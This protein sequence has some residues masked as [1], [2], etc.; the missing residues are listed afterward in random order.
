MSV[1]VLKVFLIEN[2]LKHTLTVLGIT[3][4]SLHNVIIYVTRYRYIAHLY[5]FAVHA[6]FYSDVVQCR[7]STPADQVCS[8]K[9]VIGL[10]CRTCFSMGNL[11]VQVSI[12][13]SVH[14][15]VPLSVNIY[16]WC[17][18]SATPL[19]VLCQS[20]WNFAC[21]FIMVWRCACGLDII[22]RLFFVTFS[23]LWT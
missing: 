19:T 1:Q 14:P 11:G 23:T 7:T 2:V 4:A 16:P 6:G 10:F 5:C 13:P 18:V 20:F 9:I 21:V 22:V 17:L 15:F 3:I 12:R 8:S